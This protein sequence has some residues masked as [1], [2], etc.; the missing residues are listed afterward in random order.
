MK[1]EILFLTVLRMSLVSGY[2]IICM[3]A[4]RWLMKR[5]PKMFSSLLW[6]IVLIRMVCP[7]SFESS[8]SLI[9]GG[10]TAAQTEEAQEEIFGAG[11]GFEGTSQ[12]MDAEGAGLSMER[13][14]TGLGGKGANA[15]ENPAESEPRVYGTAAA[16]I[17]K[18]F[19]GAGCVVWGSGIVLLS[20]I[21]I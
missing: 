19:A 11:V 10:G 16:D 5:L 14:Q 21:H 2:V 13:Q 7:V 3:L 4:V 1:P 8:Y 18:T 15:L 6:V 20:L 12:D 17:P 9:P